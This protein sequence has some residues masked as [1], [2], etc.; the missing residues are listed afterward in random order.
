MKYLLLIPIIVLT[1]CV[2]I[3]HKSG[4]K[5]SQ[6]TQTAQS[7]IFIIYFD[8]DKKDN[9]LTHINHYHDE[10][11]YLY[12]NINAVAV[13]ITAT[14]LNKKVQSYQAIDGVLQITKN[15]MVQLH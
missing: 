8:K 11:V 15:E 10:I 7:D 9:L 1:A 14:D 6:M 5:K 2:N 13:K 4:N 12:D 3:H